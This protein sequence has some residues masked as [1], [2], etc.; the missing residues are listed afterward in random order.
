MLSIATTDAPVPHPLTARRESAT[1]LEAEPLA[2]R[3]RGHRTGTEGGASMR[4]KRLRIV[5]PLALAAL[6][7]ST[8]ALSLGLVWGG[9]PARAQSITCPDVTKASF[10]NPTAIT[11]PNL[12][13]PT[14]TTFRYHG[15]TKGHTLDDVL[16]VTRR[17][18]VLDGVS[19]LEVDD[20]VLIDGSLI[21]TTKDYF[22]QDNAGNVWYFG[23]DSTAIAKNGTTSSAGSWHA[24]VNGAQ[25]G[26]VMEASP[27]VGDTYCQENVPGIAEDRAQ[28]VAVGQSLTVPYATFNHNVLETKEFTPLEPGKIENKFYG[29]CVGEIKAD[30]TNGGTE[31]Q[32]LTSV[33]PALTPC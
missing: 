3:R 11:N 4:I 13:F 15:I 6:L 12:P 9:Q 22:T 16:A 27:K 24:G 5:G 18:V 21:E 10:S 32:E 29:R 25:P 23:E 1:L 33:S 2:G 17:T 19:A 7:S 28:V 20:N 8:L 31:E 30:A 14:G 26:I